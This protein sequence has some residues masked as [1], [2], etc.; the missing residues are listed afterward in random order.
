VLGRSFEWLRQIEVGQRAVK[1]E[2]ESQIREVVSTLKHMKEAQRSQRGKL[3]SSFA[4]PQVAARPR[5][6]LNT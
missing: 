1:S 5:A 6:E 2:I 3:K 4:L